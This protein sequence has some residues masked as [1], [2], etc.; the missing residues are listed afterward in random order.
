MNVIY[1]RKDEFRRLVYERSE[2]FLDRIHEPSAFIV[3]EFY[4]SSDILSLRGRIFETGRLTEPSWHPLHDDCPDYHRLHDNYPQAYVRAKMHAFYYHGWYAANADLFAYFGEIFAIK[5]FLAGCPKETFITNIPSTG[6][7][8]RIN[9]HNY[10]RGGG[11][12]AEHIDP[13]FKLASIQTLVQASSCRKDFSVGGLYARA[14]D[15]AEKSYL[16]PLTSPGDLV[17]ISPGIPHGVDA[18]DPKEDY[19]W[20]EDSGKWT[21][22]PVIVNSDYPNPSH[23]KPRELGRSRES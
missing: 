13:V 1:L 17:V 20:R 23:V 19:R 2:A 12:L 16:D 14:S 6:P 10:P 21:I 7:V 3:R 22:L 5:S 9:F 8:A 15:G 4:D 18:I 11:Y